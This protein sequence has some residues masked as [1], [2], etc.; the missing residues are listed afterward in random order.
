MALFKE[1]KCPRCDRRYS[2]IRRRCPHCGARKNRGG[3]RAASGTQRWQLIVGTIVLI[4]IL[5]AVIVL[6]STSLSRNPE[7]SDRYS[8]SPDTEGGINSVTPSPSPSLLPSP[9]PSPS[10]TPTVTA[11]ALNR[12]DFTLFN[13]GDTFQMEAT[14]SPATTEATV[15][16]MSMDESVCTI[17]ENGVVTAVDRGTTTVVATAGAARAECIVRID[18]DAP[19]GSVTT[20]SDPNT[21]TGGGTLSLSHSDVTLFSVG[22]TF[23][24]TVSGTSSAPS[25]S[26]GDSS[27]CTVSS[28]GEVTAV[29]EGTT[30]VTVSVDGQTLSCIVRVF[31]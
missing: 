23:Y 8:P 12:E 6:V 9:T 14:L 7:Q 18:A 29:G 25:Y 21:G 11:I 16:W 24:L 1:I 2:S 17:D 13:V 4:A 15:E 20:T 10:P 5:V 27:V 19:A 22:E 31:L 28:D 3:K 30:E 26:S